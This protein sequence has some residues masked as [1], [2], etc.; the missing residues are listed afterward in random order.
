MHPG[1]ISCPPEASLR[2]VARM[3]AS[4]RVHAIIV[5]EHDEDRLPGGQGWGVVTDVDVVRAGLHADLDEL[6]AV[7]VAATPVLTVSTA[8]RLERA[9]QL[10]TEHEVTHLIVVE[11]HSGRPI[12]VLSTLDVA[13]VLSGRA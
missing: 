11:R 5:H 12:G 9:M 8:D 4:Y 3:M 1:M 2:T 7:Q 10:M 13:R 6:T